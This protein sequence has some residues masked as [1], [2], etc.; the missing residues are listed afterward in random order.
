MGRKRGRLAQ[1]LRIGS[2]D[3]KVQVRVPGETE[4]LEKVLDRRVDEGY[5]RGYKRRKEIGGKKRGSA[6]RE[7]TS[8]GKR[9]VEERGSREKKSEEREERRGAKKRRKEAEGKK[10]KKRNRRRGKGG[11]VVELRYTGRGRP[12]RQSRESRSKP[13]RG[14]MR[15]KRELWGRGEENGRRRRQTTEGRKR[16]EEAIKNELGGMRRRRAK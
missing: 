3:G 5:R 13:S 6:Y 16:L 7:R 8:K 15:K 9:D 1:A 4:G 12:V 11:R 2:R 10:G 14:R